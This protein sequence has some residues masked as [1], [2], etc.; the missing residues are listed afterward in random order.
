MEGFLAIYPQ[1]LAPSCW[2][3]TLSLT[4]LS[5]RVSRWAAQTRHKSSVQVLDLPGFW[6][7]NIPTCSFL[8]LSTYVSAG[9]HSCLA[10]L[11]SQSI[12]PWSIDSQYAPCDDTLETFHNRENQMVQADT[13]GFYSLSVFAYPSS[14]AD[15]FHPICHDILLLS[16]HGSCMF[17]LMNCFMLAAKKL[18][19]KRFDKVSY[20]VM[21]LVSSKNPAPFLEKKFL[22]NLSISAPRRCFYQCFFGCWNTGQIQTIIY[23]CFLLGCQFPG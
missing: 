6:W 16:P 22:G 7:S 13:E 18:L 4:L 12:P 21:A 17:Y 10:V 2:L 23:L 20:H 15:G 8:N 14:E 5:V 3:L 9:N 11:S 1:V 19:C